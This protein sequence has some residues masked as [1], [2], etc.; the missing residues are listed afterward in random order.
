[1]VDAYKGPTAPKGAVSV[2][3]KLDAVVSDH[4]VVNLPK[5]HGSKDLS[6]LSDTF[7]KK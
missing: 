2:S 5:G 6:P 4:G 1:M 3:G 7:K